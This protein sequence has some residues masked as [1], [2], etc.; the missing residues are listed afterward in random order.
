MRP[1]FGTRVRVARPQQCRARTQTS[2]TVLAAADT[3]SAEPIT[4][5]RLIG[6]IDVKSDVVVPSLEVIEASH[7]QEDSIAEPPSGEAAAATTAIDRDIELLDGLCN[8]LFDFAQH[9][10]L[11]VPFFANLIRQESGFRTDVVSPAGRA[12]HRA[13]HAAGRGGRRS[14]GPVRSDPSAAASGGFLSRAACEASAT[15]D[16]RRRPTTPAPP[17][18]RLDGTARQAAAR[19]ADLCRA[20]HRP[21]GGRMAQKPARRVGP[22]LHA[23][24]AMPRASGLRQPGA[25]A[26]AGTAGAGTASAGTASAAQQV[27]QAAPEEPQQQYM[28]QRW[29]RRLSGVGA[30]QRAHMCA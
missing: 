11:P 21:L 5:D 28:P 6:S 22:A 25:G 30:S 15:S 24:A 26:G 18:Q 12:R 19:D 27:Q 8:T 10:N 9:N 4:I 16:L 14:D 13:V 1:I 3:P 2:N 17:R 20:H 7:E 23:A 29:S